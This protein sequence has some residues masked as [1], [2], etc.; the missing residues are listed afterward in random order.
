MRI[1]GKEP[2]L[3][4]NLGRRQDVIRIQELDEVAR[5]NLQCLIA[6]NAWSTVISS[7]EVRSFAEMVGDNISWSIR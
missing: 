5:S 6:S 7:E 3:A 2:D 1:L 4:T